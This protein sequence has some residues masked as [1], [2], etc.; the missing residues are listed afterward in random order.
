MVT[1]VLERRKETGEKPMIILGISG[2]ARKKSYNTALLR[3]AKEL[4]PPGVE[5]EIFGISDL[6]MFNQDVETSPPD[7]VRRFKDEI[8]SADAVLFSTPEHNYSVTA[9]LKNAIEWGNRP[10]TD[11]SWDGKPAAVMSA[12]TS[13]RGGARAQ[14]QLRQIMIDLNMYA[15]N[16]PQL[17][18]AEARGKF[19]S[20]PKLTDD[21]V[22]A[23]LRDFV[24]ALVDWTKRMQSSGISA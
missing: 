12:S 8:R 15:M 3:E 13:M 23:R 17:L 1:Q 11:N 7:L 16:Q 2:S 19:D 21:K 4:V 22:R 6:P 24:M 10:P 14:L 18:V 20:E 5:L 9:L